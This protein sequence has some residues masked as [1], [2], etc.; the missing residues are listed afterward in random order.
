MLPPL[1]GHPMWVSY[2]DPYVSVVLSAV[3]FFLSQGMVPVTLPMNPI[4]KPVP[5]ATFIL[6][7]HKK[8]DA[9]QVIGSG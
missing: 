1:L 3:I 5:V 8:I 4:L 6:P 9:V 2:A 7:H